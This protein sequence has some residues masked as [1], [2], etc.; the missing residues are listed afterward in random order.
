MD[1]REKRED[2]SWAEY[3]ARMASMGIAPTES[4]MLAGPMVDQFRPTGSDYTPQQLRTPT[5]QLQQQNIPQNVVPI[6]PADFA[7]AGMGTVD[8]PTFIPPADIQ[9]PIDVQTQVDTFVP[10][11]DYAQVMADAG[12]APVVPA[13]VAPAPF[14]EVSF[15]PPVTIAPEV[16][17]EDVLFDR[18]RLSVGVCWW[19][20]YLK[21][22]NFI[23]LIFQQL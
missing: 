19:D 8:M 15:T 5:R 1:P 13:P 21:N 20:R 16:T 10:R 17:Y 11:G 9:P 3:G 7:Q 12:V 6:T 2:E 23:F 14:E 18:S 4:P 22:F